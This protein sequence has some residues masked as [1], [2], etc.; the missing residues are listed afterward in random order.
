M[1]WRSSIIVMHLHDRY[2]SRW[3]TIGGVDH[4][5]EAADSSGDGGSTG[6]GS[7]RVREGAGRLAPKPSAGGVQLCGKGRKRH[8][9]PH[10]IRRT[11]FA[12]GS[13]GLGQGRGKCEKGRLHGI[14]LAVSRRWRHLPPLRG[15]RRQ[16]LPLR[17]AAGGWA[18]RSGAGMPVLWRSGD[19]RPETAVTFPRPHACRREK[20]VAF[21]QD[22]VDRHRAGGAGADRRR[23]AVTASACRGGGL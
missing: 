8:L 22:F 4:G 14:Y 19:T 13:Q 11:L 2:P 7:G 20:D 9:Q 16:N 18:S 12:T 23:A 21:R 15:Q 17:Q 6:S 5:R 1:H 3:T 10:D